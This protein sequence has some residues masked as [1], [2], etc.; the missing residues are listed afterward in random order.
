MVPLFHHKALINHDNLSGIV[1]V[2]EQSDEWG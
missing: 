2:S 1:L